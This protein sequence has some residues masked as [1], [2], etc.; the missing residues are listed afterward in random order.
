M[1]HPPGYDIER[2]SGWAVR[3]NSWAEG[4]EASISCST[5]HRCDIRVQCLTHVLLCIGTCTSLCFLCD[6]TR[7]ASLICGSLRRFLLALR[8][9]CRQA[10]VQ[11]VCCA[12]VIAVMHHF[13]GT[14]W[15]CSLGAGLV[16]LLSEGSI[17]VHAGKELSYR[18]PPQ[19]ISSC[20]AC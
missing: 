5:W 20:S 8:Q 13:S 6:I 10:H 4:E 7:H 18:C 19:V 9:A 11:A 16:C 2:Q 14:A 3:N 12:S 1:C 15:F 17:G